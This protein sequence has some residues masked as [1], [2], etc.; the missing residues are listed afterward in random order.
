M[1]QSRQAPKAFQPFEGLDPWEKMTFWEKSLDVL[2]RGQYAS[3]AFAESLVKGTGNPFREALRGLKGEKRTSYSDVLGAVGYDK[4]L[5]RGVIGFAGDVLLDPTTYLTFGAGAGV[6]ATVGGVQKVITKGAAAARAAHLAEK[7][8]QAERILGRTRRGVTTILERIPGAPLPR[9]TEARVEK[10]LGSMGLRGITEGLPPAV[11]S[12]ILGEVATSKA[13]GKAVAGEVVAGPIGKMLT[14]KPGVQ[15]AVHEMAPGVVGAVIKSAPEYAKIVQPTTLRLAGLPIIPP[16]VI[17]A[18]GR[19]ARTAWDAAESSAVIGPLA[20][21]ARLAGETLKN[22]AKRVM[23]TK[24]GIP[25]LDEIIR[26][27]SDVLDFRTMQVVRKYVDSY[28]KPLK[29]MFKSDPAGYDNALAQI[30]TY[31]EGVE[32]VAKKEI[33]DPEK[34]DAITAHLEEL[35]DRITAAEAALKGAEE[36]TMTAFIARE[37]ARREHARL[38]TMGEKK[39]AEQAFKAEFGDIKRALRTEGIAGI[40]GIPYGGYEFVKNIPKH[41]RR[42]KGKPIDEWI[43]ELERKRLLEPG[44]TQE[45]FYAFLQ[46]MA[47]G[48]KKLSVEEILGKMP[49]PPKKGVDPTIETSIAG[50]KE[51]FA[52]QL[53]ARREVPMVTVSE[54]KRL[55]GEEAVAAATTRE[56]LK[57]F[58][59]PMQEKVRE[60]A[61]ALKG[62]FEAVWEAENR[63]LPLPPEKMIGY[64]PHYLKDEVREMLVNVVRSDHR[65]IL[66]REWVGSLNEAQRREWLTN[67]DK[68]TITRMLEETKAIDPSK[69]QGVL[70][71]RGIHLSADDMLVFEPNPIYAALKRELHSVRALNNTDMAREVLESPLFVKAKVRLGDTRNI[72]AILNEHPEH[73]L[74]VPT[75]SY[76]EK[77]RTPAEREAMRLGKDKILAGSLLQVVDKVELDEIAKNIEKSGVEAF[78]LPKEVA[79][80]LSR[81]YSVQFDEVAFKEFANMWD[82]MSGWW[83]TFATVVRPGFHVRNEVSNL[84]QMYLAGMTSPAPLSK[85]LGILV[86]PSTAPGVGNW[87]AQEILALSDR[88]G[89]RRTGFIGG[90][91]EDLVK[92]EVSPEGFMGEKG[93]L[94]KFPGKGILSTSGPLARAGTKIGTNLEDH[95]RFALFIDGIEKG[96]DPT[97]AAMRVKKYMFDYRDLTKWERGIFRRV[98]PFYTWTRKSIPLAF[99]T[100]FTKPGDVSALGKIRTAGEKNIEGELDREYLTS[101]I[102]DGMGVPVRKTVDGKYEYFLLKGWIPTADL[103]KLDMQEAFGMLH[104]AIKTA[105]EQSVNQNIYLRR[106]IERFP[107]EKE[108]LLGVDVSKRVGHL[109]RNVVL[110]QEL[111]RLFFQQD[112]PLAERGVAAGLGL[113]T[114]KQD[115]VVQMRSYVYDLQRKMGDLKNAISLASKKYGGESTI[116]QRA[117]EELDKTILERDRVKDDLLSIDPDALSTKKEGPPKPE[118][119]PT[120]LEGFRRKISLENLLRPKKK[121]AGR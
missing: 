56:G 98:I 121:A 38:L 75:K 46:K 33:P 117:Q 10:L 2:A 51:Q 13:M 65:K 41:L 45:D 6:K 118:R 120:S 74:F 78:I 81:A 72:K 119:M 26:R 54:T 90:E 11:T 37:A 47:A 12:K 57:R 24:T 114:Y 106:P 115:K 95:A 111:D 101:F 112:I 27:A 68:A 62:N 89:I 93:M 8:V 53:A 25:E 42:L 17:S 1:S 109:V 84:W 21:G 100:L 92:R 15:A 86:N 102:R 52:K 16:K 83:K 40:P 97:G 61:E 58:A 22:F 94:P 80:H 28:V 103:F 76:I 105:I 110:A 18:A 70:K 20:R 4:G 31:L 30:R 64:M 91:I 116:A 23:S 59:E 108:K 19:A 29:A 5:A 43:S 39:I 32:T 66:R 104:P 63:K 113:R 50:L 96:M 73:A 99:E 3:A 9:M 77:F 71:D 107:G 36:E 82:R 55:L 44:S 48:P 14:L 87:T 69:I 60:I 35:N 67:V 49:V 85:A 88:F 7:T 79:D 34:F